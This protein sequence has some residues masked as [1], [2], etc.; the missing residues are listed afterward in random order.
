MLSNATRYAR[1][2]G[3]RYQ[4]P[5]GQKLRWMSAKRIQLRAS[6]CG[7]A[8][9]AATARRIA[10]RFGSSGDILLI[11]RRTT[12]ALCANNCPEPNVAIE[13]PLRLRKERR[14]NIRV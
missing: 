13:M 12:L 5:C 10:I 9:M 7:N 4:F 11:E 14:C 2:H 8:F 6:D 1:C 3:S